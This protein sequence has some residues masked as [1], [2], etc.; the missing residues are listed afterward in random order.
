MMRSTIR[1]LALLSAIGLA[2]GMMVWGGRSFHRSLEGLAHGL[3]IST[4]LRQAG[5]G[6]RALTFHWNDSSLCW[7]PRPALDLEGVEASLAFGTTW[8]GCS[9][10]ATHKRKGTGCF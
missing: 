10:R 3:D 9:F 1:R 6:G 5:L 2:L 7:W 8:P 4:I